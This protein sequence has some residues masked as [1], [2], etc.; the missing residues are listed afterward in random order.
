MD[1][2]YYPPMT[3]SPIWLALGVVILVGLIGWAVVVVTITR[4]VRQPA[5]PQPP[6]HWRLAA[7]QG[8]YLRRIDEVVRLADG[9]ELQPRRAHQELSSI[10][11]EFVEEASGVQVGTMT[12]TELA[13]SPLPSVGP[14]R[15]VVG[16]LYPL[17]FGAQAG[18]ASPVSVAAAA[19]AAREV[20][21]RWS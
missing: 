21:T 10:V 14:V 16:R 17:E 7:L 12:L 20:V 13:R 15:D 11:R 3:Y 18:D 6:P 1:G 4:R 2:D 9:A 5:P 8:D 19:A